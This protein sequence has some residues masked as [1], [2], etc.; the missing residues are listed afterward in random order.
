MTIYIVIC[1]VAFLASTLTFFSGFGLGT[2]LLAAF[3]VFFEIETAVALTA[4]VHFL[5]GAFK[6][7]LV[8][9]HV[10]W[11]VFWRFGLPAIAGALLGASALLWLADAPPLVVY[12]AFGRVAEVTPVK[13][14]VGLLLLG[15]ASA[16]LWPPFGRLRLTE[17]HM[18][19]G[20]LLSGFFGGLAGMQGALRS[21]F[22]VKAGLGKEAYIATG[23]AIAFA[24]D[25]SRLGVY[26]QLVA[27]RQHDLPL[28]LLAAAVACAMLGVIVGN[29]Y[30]RKAT[31]DAISAVVAALLFLLSLGL[32]SG[33]L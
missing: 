21:A 20:G 9:R 8:R 22:L 28:S 24:I 1:V 25:V 18:P 10:D 12:E 6:L 16:E 19:A 7:V 31:M 5:N 13:L 30:L 17:R 33:T 15:F 2:L 26:S 4:I 29:H 11:H 23:A 32:L 14:A 3:A 27:E